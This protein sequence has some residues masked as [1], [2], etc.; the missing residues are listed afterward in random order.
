MKNQTRKDVPLGAIIPQGSLATALRAVRDPRRPFG[1]QPQHPP[2]PLVA[3]LLL[4]IV[5]MLCGAN[6]QSAIAQWGR[7]RLE[8]HPDRLKALGLPVGQ[9]PATVTLHRLFR[10]LDVVQF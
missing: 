6:S 7:E 9:C 2:L 3:L 8:D 4:T 10:R 1:W 5:A